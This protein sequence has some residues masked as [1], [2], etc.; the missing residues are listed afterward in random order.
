[1]GFEN[2]H[3][4]AADYAAKPQDTR[5]PLELIGVPMDAGAGRRGVC[6]GPEALRVAGIENAFRALG[7][8]VSDGGD[9]SGPRSPDTAPKDG[10]RHLSEVAAWTAAIRDRVAA[11]LENGNRPVILGG[12]HSLSIGSVGGIAKVCRA[13]SIPLSV[14]WIDAHADFNTPET[15]PSGN[16]HGMPLATLCGHLDEPALT[17]LGPG[18]AA[19]APENVHLVG[20][21]SVD[22][23]E[24]ARV[25]ESGANVYDMKVIDERGMTSVMREV[26]ANVAATGGH[27]H[28]SFDVDVL[29][30]S[31]A[32]GV[33]TPVPGGATYREAHLCMEMIHDSGLLGSLDLVELNPCLDDANKSA[34]LLVDLAGSAL[35]KQIISRRTAA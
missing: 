34:E 11:S 2:N 20:I 3:I 7:H 32:P 35:G 14:L 10:Y 4:S 27:L 26:L 5:R 22:P 19:V 31:I 15:S 29:D 16:I 30:P 21:R 17:P 28:V 18:T 12:D 23:V 1:M 9:I 8:G 6:L 24:K 13:R 25:V 33:G